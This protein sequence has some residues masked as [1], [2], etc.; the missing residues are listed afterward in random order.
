MKK[1]LG[2]RGGC[3]ER[4]GEHW[5]RAFWGGLKSG[6]SGIRHYE[7]V[8]EDYNQVIGGIKCILNY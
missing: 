4:R 7:T 5:E 3:L 8:G 6:G 1:S 2:E